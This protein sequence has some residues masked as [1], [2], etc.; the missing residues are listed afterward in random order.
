MTRIAPLPRS[1]FGPSARL[2]DLVV[3]RLVGRHLD[4]VGIAA[5]VPAILRASGGMERAFM[6]RRAVSHRMLELVSVRAAMEIGCSF[7]L[8]MGSYLAQEKSGATEDEIRGLSDHAGS[9]VF[10]P[11]EVAAFDLAVAMSATPPT[12]D[13]ELWARLSEHWSDEQLVELTAM[14]GW[15]NSRAR[16]ANA[17]GIQSHGLTAGGA[18]A[19]ATVHATTTTPTSSVAA[20]PPALR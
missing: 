20:A 8:D 13:D 7:C 11:G 15:E 17:L 1:K 6:G 16:L 14:I 3:R 9:G 18:C 10:T 19:V 12:V 5:R 4:G 2:T